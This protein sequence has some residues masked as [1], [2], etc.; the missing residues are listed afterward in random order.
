MTTIPR[1]SFWLK[2]NLTTSGMKKA[3]FFALGA[4]LLQL[5]SFYAAQNNHH[6]VNAFS[7]PVVMWCAILFFAGSQY[8]PILLLTSFGGLFVFDT[9]VGLAAT[10]ALTPSQS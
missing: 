5:A 4:L 2:H 8:W 3:V 6:V 9:P 10:Y 7:F 1:Q